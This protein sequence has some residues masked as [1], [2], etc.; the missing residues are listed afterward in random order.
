MQNCIIWLIIEFTIMPVGAGKSLPS[1]L[2]FRGQFILRARIDESPEEQGRLHV[3]LAQQ[4][5][6]PKN[7]SPVDVGKGIEAKLDQ[8]LEALRCMTLDAL[9]AAYFQ[10]ALHGVLGASVLFAIL[11]S[12]AR[13]GAS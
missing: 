2:S 9:K 11:I 4:T 13:K 5:P 3:P 8:L 1:D 7:A 10:G 12:F 6:S